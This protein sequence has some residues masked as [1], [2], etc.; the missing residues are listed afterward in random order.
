VRRPARLVLL[1]AALGAGFLL[2]DARGEDVVLV[3]DLAAAPAATGLEVELRRD[4]GLVRRAS[5]RVAG[6]GQVRHSVNL[7]RGEYALAWRVTGPAGGGA[8]RRAIV[9]EEEGTIVLP[10]TP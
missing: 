9:V 5:F 8:G 7:R 4:G 2:F 3:Y 1:L 10:L 6:G